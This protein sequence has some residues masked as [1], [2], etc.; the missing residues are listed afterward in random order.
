MKTEIYNDVSELLERIS[1]FSDRISA[2]IPGRHAGICGFD[3]FIDTFIRV[4]EPPTMDEFGRKVAK[5]AGMAASYPVHHL[6]DKFGGNGPLF[7]VALNDIYQGDIDITYIGALGKHAI[8]PIF[9]EALAAKV[10]KA[11]S[12]ADPA[13]SDCLEFHDGKVML[14]DMRSCADVRWEALLEH[15]GIDKIDALL[16]QSRFIAALNWGKLVNVGEVWENLALRLRELDIPKKEV[17]FFMDL[18]EFEQRPRED[19]QELVELIAKITPQCTTI[20]SLN[21]KEA[22]QLADQFGGEFH[23]RKAPAEVAEVAAFVKQFVEVDQVLVHPNDG[24]ASAGTDGCIYIPGPF[25]Q[26]PLISTGAGDNFGAGC[27]A[28]LLSGMDACDVL[29]S[30]ACASGYFVRTG[31]SPAYAEIGRVAALWAEGKLP[32]RL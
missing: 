19:R 4:Q 28:A 20:L 30:G 22:W 11:Y 15:V 25:C 18:A 32:E 27:L 31:R 24:A 16:K 17:T 13:H 6:G 7:A 23:G 2:F 26:Q 5:A 14:S 1:A 9:Q 21:L 10:R 12:V 29:L 8:L 3:G